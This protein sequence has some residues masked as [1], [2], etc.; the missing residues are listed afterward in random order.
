MTTP[1]DFVRSD[2]AHERALLSLTSCVVPASR[3]P[4]QVFALECKHFDFFDFDVVF[5]EQFWNLLVGIARANGDSEVILGVL[6][7]DP[8]Y[9]RKHFGYF[10]EAVLDISATASEY[11]DLI[12]REPVD[13]PA[14]ALRHV[15]NVM[16]YCGPS[17]AWAIWTQRDLGLGVVALDNGS[18]P[19]PA[20]VRR[21]IHWFSA[22]EALEALVAPNFLTAGTPQEVAQRLIENYPASW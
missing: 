15:A 19:F 2:H 22:R 16:V 9:F 17:H 8:T 10:G 13:S 14:D 4:D 20:S 5:E 12:S 6:D 21:S 3:L 18:S 11:Q 7:P 1:L